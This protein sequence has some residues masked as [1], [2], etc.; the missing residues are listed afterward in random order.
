MIRSKL[1]FEKRGCSFVKASVQSEKNYKLKAFNK[2]KKTGIQL[3]IML[4]GLNVWLELL[5]E[6]WSCRKRNPTHAHH[7]SCL[8]VLQFHLVM[9]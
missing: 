1:C 9:P 2:K 4:K 7:S 3:N 5:M 6:I 8:W